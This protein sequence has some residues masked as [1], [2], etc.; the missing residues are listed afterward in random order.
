ME[1]ARALIV[2]DDPSWQQLLREMLEEMGLA[3]DVA[4]SYEEARVQMRAH[5]HRLAVV[6]LSLR[7][8]DPHDQTGL[9]VLDALRAHDPTCVPILLTGYATVETAV[10][11]LTQHGAFTVLRKE[12]FRR[13]EFR[14]EVRKALAQMPPRGHT[15]QDPI[16]TPARGRVLIVE[17]DAGWQEVLAE[18][19]QEAGLFPRTCASFGEALGY[20]RREPYALAVVD[21][22]LAS[23]LHPQENRDGYRL[24]RS[25]REAGIP[26]LVVTGMASPEEV[27]QVYR[28]GAFACVEKQSFSRRAFVQLVEEAIQQGH[29][30]LALLTPREREVLELL[31]QGLTNKEIA[32]QLVISPN[33]VKRHV[34]AI[35][36]KLGVKTRAAAV[37]K[38]TQGGGM[39]D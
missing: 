24:L 31:A 12:T 21:L 28:E 2:E 17:D 18:L 7:F 22:A 10:E 32:R 26:T 16:T 5:A 4:T 9:Q 38:W 1:E 34:Q 19:V 39:N 33:T 11:A 29:T 6:D 20:L 14:E 27:E 13:R 37:A 36:D 15:T 8:L 30:S 3:V 25:T 35:F 23:S